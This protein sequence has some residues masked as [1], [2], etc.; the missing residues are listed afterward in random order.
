MSEEFECDG[1][2]EN[3]LYYDVELGECTLEDDFDECPLGDELNELVCAWK[4]KFGD[5]EVK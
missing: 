3:C 1:N 5:K 4:L 2:C